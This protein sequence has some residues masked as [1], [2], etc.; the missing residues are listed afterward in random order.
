MV[1]KG[2]FHVSYP[3]INN[4]FYWEFC[5]HLP[6]IKVTVKRVQLLTYA[7][8]RILVSAIEHAIL[9]QAVVEVVRVIE[10]LLRGVVRSRALGPGQVLIVLVD[11]AHDQAFLYAGLHLVEVHREDC[12]VGFVVVEVAVFPV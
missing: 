1:S 12:L 3:V 4:E 10:H 7:P 8:F 11:Q 2:E 9:L 5:P 6:I